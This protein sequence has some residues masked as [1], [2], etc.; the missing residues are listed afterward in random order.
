MKKRLIT[1][2]L[3]GAMTATA[4]ADTE[5]TVITFDD[6]LEGWN[7]I[8]G[9]GGSSQ[10]VQTGGNPG[11]HIHTVFNNFG[12]YWW[13]NTNQ[14]FLGDLTQ[15]ESVTIGVD[16]KVEGIWFFG[17]PVTRNLILDLR[18]F[19]LAQGNYPWTSVW[20]KMTTL[21]AGPNWASYEVTFNPSSEE[22]PEGWG[23]YGDETPFAEPILPEGVSFADVLA[24]VQEMAFTTLEPGFVYGFTDFDI[25]IDNIRIDVTLPDTGPVGDLNGDGVV[26][27]L[28]L[29]IL[30][31]NW[32]ACPNRGN[33]PADLNEDGTVNVLDLLVLLENWG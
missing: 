25:R 30:L 3:A 29:L 17:S 2:C 14:N 26:N 5:S 15:Y 1:V 7:G 13:T 22:L 20:Y 11:A 33:C 27:V 9:P 19:D 18:S 31:E 10:L 21:Q 6:G 12:V 24:N 32:G 4:L 16:V 8:Q 23:G 28:D